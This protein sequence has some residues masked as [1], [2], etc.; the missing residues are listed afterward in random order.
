MAIKDR[1][2]SKDTSARTKNKKGKAKVKVEVGS[3]GAFSRGDL[4]TSTH[5]DSS[6][7]VGV[8]TR[9]ETKRITEKTTGDVIWVQWRHPSDGNGSRDNGNAIQTLPTL[10][11]RQGQALLDDDDEY[12]YDR[13]VGHDSLSAAGYWSGDLTILSKA[14][15]DI[16]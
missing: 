7:V 15:T 5:P 9:V 12:G 8:V 6:N 14:P 4:V 1:R 10:A 3:A 2:S 16:K 13:T 11:A